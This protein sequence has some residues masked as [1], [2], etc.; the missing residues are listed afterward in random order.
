MIVS[1][2]T[3]S[4]KSALALALAEA[5]Q[6]TIVNADS[7]QTYRDLAI[8]TARPDRA[9]LARAP[10]RLYGYRDAAERGSAAA[11]RRLA[12][13]EI[14]AATG[15]G[16]LPIVVGGTGLYLRALTEGLAPVPDIPEEI[17][18]EAVA[19][20]RALGGARFRERL[21]MLDPE[22]ARRLP[23][24]DTQRL[25]RAFE[26]VRATGRPIAAWQC[27]PHEPAPY[28]FAT[29]RLMPPRDQLYAA[30]DRRFAAMVA[31]GALAEAAALRARNLDPGLP[32]MKA[33]GLPEL[34][35]HLDGRL[36]LAAAL[37][38]GQQATRHYAKRQITWLRHQ[39]AADL[40]LTEPFSAEALA[41]SQRFIKGFLLTGQ[42]RPT[43][44]AS[45][46]IP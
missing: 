19:L 41:C 33:I 11:W 9:A 24:G 36:P 40:V 14:A 12:Q 38:A 43:T 23:A 44:V 32:A 35:A 4:G 20:H 6:G 31:A 28:R 1:G 30:C 16:R 42:T 10:H 22:A 45:G 3:A 7:L 25:V 13:D 8:L 34:F 46:A 21:A 5:F 15:S 29:I 27:R 26:V 39:S 17:R 2:P 18:R 37:A